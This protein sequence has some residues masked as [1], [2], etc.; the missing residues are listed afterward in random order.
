MKASGSPWS[1]S[2]GDP[3]VIDSTK[4]VQMACELKRSQGKRGSDVEE[5]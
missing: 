4:V 1:L 5:Q 3:H 2:L